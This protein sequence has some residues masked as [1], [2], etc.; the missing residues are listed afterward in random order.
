VIAALSA[1][2]SAVVFVVQRRHRPSAVTAVESLFRRERPNRDK[3]DGQRVGPFDQIQGRVAAVVTDPGG[4]T[5]YYL[6]DGWLQRRKKE[7][8]CIK[9]E[10]RVD[11]TTNRQRDT[12][13]IG[14]I[15]TNPIILM[16]R[17]LMHTT[18]HCTV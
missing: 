15:A 12:F 6:F 9:V 18:A 13:M 5:L 10:E 17:M 16:R 3:E 4:V 7:E 14:S 8:H 11:G 1:S 2:C